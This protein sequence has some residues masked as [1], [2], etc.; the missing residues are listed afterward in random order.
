VSSPYV[1][2]SDASP[3]TF[4]YFMEVLDGTSFP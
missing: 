2:Q 1:V 3:D 4:A